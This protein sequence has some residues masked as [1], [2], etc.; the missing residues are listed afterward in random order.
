VNARKV[1]LRRVLLMA[2]PAFFDKVSELCRQPNFA[3]YLS[4]ETVALVGIWAQKI[5][6]GWL[7]WELTKSNFW[8]GAIA[9]ADLFPTVVIT[10]VAGVI[11]DRV[12]RLNMARLCQALAG[13]HAFLMAALIY[14]DLINIW[15]LFG[16]TFILGVVLAFATAARLAM[17]PNLIDVKHVPTAI[18]MNSSIYNIA[19]VIGPMVAAAMISLFSIGATFLLTG[20]TYVVF[21]FCMYRIHLLRSESSHRRGKLF[22]E[23]AEG[24]RYAARHP[25][26]GP[27]LILLI[28]AAIGI[29]PFLELLPGLADGVFRAGV[30]GFATFAAVAGAGAII[31]G[32]W[33]ALRDSSRGTTRI[34]F[35]S[36]LLGVLGM[37]IVCATQIFWVG[38][39]GTF[40]VGAAITLAG[41]ATQILMQLSVEGE[42][43]G[44]VMSL[45]GMVHRGVP[46]LGAVIIGV[47]AELVGLQAAMYGGAALTG[48]VFVLM[49]RRYASMVAVLEPDDNQP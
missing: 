23:T 24:M 27:A 20:F 17:V 9:F 16:L 25:A 22:T 44:R 41:T 28:G 11:A 45:Y 33:M 18:G 30:E 32:V 19:R 21:V 26:I 38:L 1:S 12:N 15:S 29:K 47:A 40:L 48:L 13:L 39:L 3:W 35:G 10:P 14:L 37:V 2:G 42:V 6:I 36:M 5:A 43:R 4:G 46:A 7:T 8:L 49:L 31:A 34:A